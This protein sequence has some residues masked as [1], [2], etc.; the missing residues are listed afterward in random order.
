MS[1][2]PD[3]VSTVNVEAWDATNHG[4]LSYVKTP[5][6]TTFFVNNSDLIGKAL[7]QA[8]I[9]FTN[10][11]ATADQRTCVLGNEFRSTRTHRYHLPPPAD[12]KT[13]EMTLMEITTYAPIAFDYMRT[14]IGILR[15]DF[16]SSFSNGE[17]LNF[18][19]TGRSGSQMYKT[20][21]DVSIFLV[22][23][24]NSMI[25]FSVISSKQCVIM[26]RN[27]YFKLYQVF[28]YVILRHHL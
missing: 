12:S 24:S 25:R 9:Y 26:K 16:L 6:Q 8:I 18:A 14:M 2:Q 13:S 4:L 15:N 17:L 23:S 1:K 22:I 21:D 11:L 7:R 19:N 5:I 10:T 20:P 27:Y 3:T 28:I